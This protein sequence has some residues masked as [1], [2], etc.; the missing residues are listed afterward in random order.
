MIIISTEDY[1][2][3]IISL[4]CIIF[5]LSSLSCKKKT[6]T[7]IKE[8]TTKSGIEMIFVP[9]GEFIMGDG[10]ADAPL[11]KVKISS[12][13]MDKYEVTQKMYKTLDLPN[14]S[15]FKGENRPAE[16]VAWINAAIYCN[17]R[18]IEEGLTPC[19]DEKTW[20]CNFDANGYRLPTEAEWEYAAK[21]GTSGKFFFG[22]DPKNLKNYAVFSKNSHG[23][24]ET[25][26][27]K[28]PNPW[29]FFDIYGNVAE[30]CND[31]YD[32]DYYKNSPSRDP[33][34]PK[35]GNER[36]IRGGSWN[37]SEEIVNSTARSKDPSLSDACILRDTIGFRCV[38]K[39]D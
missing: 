34:G 22:P 10:S 21:A 4:M 36:V 28:K 33:R 14:P 3:K 17:E 11:H 7:S 32:K 35:N 12:F 1:M 23:K 27:S 26:G 5:I 2:K 37:D 24:T 18:S 38:R 6:E 8:I 9:E 20:E 31:F 15:H 39:G 25:T 29:G 16:M 19:Y 13:Y 30:W